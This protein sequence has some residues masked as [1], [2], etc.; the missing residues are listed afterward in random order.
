[1]KRILSDLTIL[2]ACMAIGLLA[3]A[4]PSNHS[5]VANHDHA[6]ET[7]QPGTDLKPCIIHSTGHQNIVG[8]QTSDGHCPD[9]THEVLYPGPFSAAALPDNHDA[10]HP[11][12]PPSQRPHRALLIEEPPRA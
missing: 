5:R 3:F 2:V 8:E 7:V 6:T 11:L 9:H 4:G 1:M 12:P 10:P